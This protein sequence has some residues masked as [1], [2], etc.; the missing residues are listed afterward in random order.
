MGKKLKLTK[1]ELE[2]R[3]G[4]KVELS[5]DEAKELYEQLN[6]LFGDKTVYIPNQPII[7]ERDRWVPTYPITWTSGTTAKI[8]NENVNLTASFCEV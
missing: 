3:E 5:M 2:T 6:D 7:I 1:L 4:K 8:E